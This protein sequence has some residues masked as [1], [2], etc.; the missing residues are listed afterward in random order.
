MSR[1]DSRSRDYQVLLDTIFGEASEERQITQRAIAWVIKNRVDLNRPYWG[2]KKIAD[3]CQHPNFFACWKSDWNRLQKK[4]LSN[5]VVYYAIDA[6]LP[7]VYL[8]PDPTSGAHYYINP[9]KEGYPSWTKL[10][11]HLVNIGNF[12][13]YKGP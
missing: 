2:G 7:D 5:P 6:W 3:V 10:C 1:L 12:E 13:F 11:Q 9:D 8:H 4:K